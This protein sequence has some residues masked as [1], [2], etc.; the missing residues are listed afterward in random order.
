MEQALIFQHQSTDFCNEIFNRLQYAT[1]L[2][3]LMNISSKEFYH[4]FQT[5]TLTF[6]LG[7]QKY[8]KP[9]G[10]NKV[11][12]TTIVIKM[13]TK[14]KIQIKISWAHTH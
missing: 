3:V 6:Q 1:D 5:L 13:M 7:V 12:A 9:T 8:K 11:G 10:L 2:C 14:N 4:G